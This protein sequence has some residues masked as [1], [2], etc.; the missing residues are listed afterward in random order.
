MKNNIMLNILR[1]FSYVLRY[2]LI[3]YICVFFVLY[4]SINQIGRIS[5]RLNSIMP[6]MANLLD[7]PKLKSKEHKKELDEYIFYYEKLTVTFPDYADSYGMLAYCHYYKGEVDRAIAYYKKAASMDAEQFWYPYNLGVI[8]YEQEQFGKAID[9]F[10]KAL[11]LNP[12]D[13]AKRMH[14]SK[15]FSQIALSAGISHEAINL[16]LEEARVRS[17]KA[18]LLCY[19]NLDRFDDLFLYAQYAKEMGYVD[20]KFYCYYLGMANY[21]MGQHKEALY[22]FEMCR[23]KDVRAYEVTTL[24]EK[25]FKDRGEDVLAARMKSRA[26]R[27]KEKSAEEDPASVDIYVQIF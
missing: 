26:K 19:F 20:A 15:T 3:V 13:A 2:S 5:T 4:A 22:H 11:G 24:M 8:Y 1:F 10:K 7:Y 21:Q 25:M 23:R 12:I 27:A 6:V 18:M 17:V 9:E 14:M 16:S